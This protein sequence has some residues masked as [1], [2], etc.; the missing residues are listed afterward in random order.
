MPL[1]TEKKVLFAGI[2]FVFGAMLVFPVTREA[3]PPSTAGTLEAA[4]NMSVARASHT[5]TLLPNGKVLITG[6]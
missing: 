2:S 1:H 5:A 3:C 6:G 4:G